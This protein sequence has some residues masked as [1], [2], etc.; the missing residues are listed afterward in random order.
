MM[1]MNA[2]IEPKVS[3]KHEVTIDLCDLSVAMAEEEKDGGELAMMR[4][5]AIA[6]IMNRY[7]DEDTTIAINSVNLSC[8][9]HVFVD[10]YEY[11]QTDSDGRCTVGLSFQDADDRELALWLVDAVGSEL[12]LDFHDSEQVGV[13]K[14]LVISLK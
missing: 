11:H 9:E 13:G 12:H 7:I 5:D 2:A 14:L 6:K 8:V 4:A 3:T 1:D 10:A